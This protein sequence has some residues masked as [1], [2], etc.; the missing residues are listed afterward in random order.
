[1]EQLAQSFA[2]QKLRRHDSGAPNTVG[3]KAPN[4]LETHNNFQI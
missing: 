1:L 4:N 3:K 2:G